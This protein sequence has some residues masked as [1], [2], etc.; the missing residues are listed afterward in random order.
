MKRTELPLD[1]QAMEQARAFSLSD[2]SEC[3]EQ[4]ELCPACQDLQDVRTINLAY[5]RVEQNLI[6]Q[7]GESFLSADDYP[8]GHDWVASET[9]KEDGTIREEF[10]E[11][12]NNLSD[13]LQGYVFLGQHIYPMYDGADIKA[14][15]MVPR[16]YA[17]CHT[18]H[19]QYN[20]SIPCPNH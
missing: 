11:P 7:E 13:R 2:C 14:Y 9:R 3:V 17:I 5:S 1:V 16:G 15:V 20:L 12:T 18:C 4:E 6:E 8:S 19:L 10:L